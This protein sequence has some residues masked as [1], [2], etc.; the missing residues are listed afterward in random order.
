MEV[1]RQM[2]PGL[3]RVFD[4]AN[5]DLHAA[6]RHETIGPQQALFLLNSPFMVAQAG[7][8]AKR[9]DGLKPADD[10]AWIRQAHLLTLG[11]Q[12]VPA[13]I[14]LSLKFLEKAA[15]LK[16]LGPL[17]PV[18]WQYGHGRWNAKTHRV[19]GF[20]TMPHFQDGSWQGGPDL[21][22][23][24][25]GFRMLTA[26]GGHPGEGLN[27]VVVRRWI[28]PFAGLVTIDGTLGHKLEQEDAEADGVHG[29]I[30]SGRDGVL[31]SA[32]AFKS[33]VTLHAKNV[34]VTAG[35]TIDFVV[36]SRAN[37]NSDKFT[38][39]VT[40]TLRRDGDAGDERSFSSV[41]DF[42]G[43]APAPAP[44]LSAREKLAQ[45]LLM[46]NEFQFVD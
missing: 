3:F 41:E 15:A 28:A 29:L 39:P 36:D 44:P 45:V 35:E 34:R 16:Q 10:V 2:L 11:R 33:A 42:R 40:L 6:R 9:I 30:V 17:V 25:L 43:P 31:A 1:D 22:D 32:S 4:F 7:A 27:Q 8:L 12:P 19:A 20:R 13:E 24:K 18:I 14:A 46:A 37:A 38:W 23:P 21:P 5:P 26:D